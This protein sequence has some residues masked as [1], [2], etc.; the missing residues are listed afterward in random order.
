MSPL[1]FIIS[2]DELGGINPEGLSELADCAP[3]SLRHVAGEGE[4]YMGLFP[5]TVGK[6]F[7][8]R[9]DERLLGPIRTPLCPGEGTGRGEMPGAGS[10]R[11]LHFYPAP[12]DVVLTG[13]PFRGSWRPSSLAG[14]NL[15]GILHPNF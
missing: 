5:R 3:L 2:A 11:T 10:C 4:S 8:A 7:F 14:P 1:G 12:Q 6:R 9:P 15:C 13:M